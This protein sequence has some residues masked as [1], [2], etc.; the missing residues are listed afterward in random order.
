MLERIL[1]NLK[2]PASCTRFDKTLFKKL[3]Y[4]HGDLKSRDK[5][6]VQEQVEKIVLHYNLTPK[7]TNIVAYQ[8]EERR[9]LELPIVSATLKE[10][11]GAARIAEIIQRT[12]PHPC[13]LL[14]VC[15]DAI[16]VHV[17][18]Q[19]IHGSDTAKITLEAMEQSEWLV[20][21]QLNEF[22]LD[23]LSSLDVSRFRFT[24]F[25]DFYS[26]LFQRVQALNAAEISGQFKEGSAS[27]VEETA[28]QLYNYRSLE[29]QLETKRSELNA[30]VHFNRKTALKLEIQELKSQLADI[31]KNL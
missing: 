6:L 29:Q 5:K 26:D 14:L 10:R 28:S 3:F 9:Y 13:L 25:Y 8:N 17:A 20:E 11:K 27:R 2:L 19:R 15:G 23:F 1:S 12:L 7:S 30:E 24:N 31:A 18:H 21:D 22:Q 4:E 16:A